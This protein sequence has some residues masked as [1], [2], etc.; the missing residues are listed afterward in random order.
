MV[1]GY[2]SVGITVWAALQVMTEMAIAFPR[3]GTFVEYAD[4]WVDP[5][6]AFAAGFA[7]WLGKTP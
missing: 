7:E 6:V 2:M 1:V 4:R 5:S 3:S